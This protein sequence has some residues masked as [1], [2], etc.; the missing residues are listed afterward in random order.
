MRT[1][2][3]RRRTMHFPAD[4]WNVGLAISQAKLRKWFA[5]RHDRFWRHGRLADVAAEKTRRT[6]PPGLSRKVRTPNWLH[7]DRTLHARALPMTNGLSAPREIVKASAIFVLVAV[8]PILVWLFRDLILLVVG[9][10]VLAALLHL[11]ARPIVSW[12]RVPRGVALA[13]AGIFISA[14]IAGVGWIFGSRVI[15]ELSDVVGRAE[16]S[17]NVIRQE[18]HGGL[19]SQVFGA[20]GPSNVSLMSYVGAALQITTGMVEAAI[21][22]IVGGVYVAAEP[23]LYRK[24]LVLIFPSY[25]SA[26][27]HELLGDLATGL[28]LWL[29]GQLIQMVLVGLLSFLVLWL[30]G[31]P[32]PVGLGVIAAVCEFIPYLGPILAGVPAVLVAFSQSTSLAIW[33]ILAFVIIHQME[34]HLFVPLVQRRFVVIPPA[35]MLFGIV[36]VDLFFGFFGILVAAPLVVLVYFCVKKLYV[37]EGLG[38]NVTVPGEEH[39]ATSNARQA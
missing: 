22:I 2:T 30:I 1:D 26:T 5:H 24:G 20:I 11:V 34:G 18:L 21:I 13:I 19:L 38:R 9:A 12:F 36:T 16:S 37:R 7:V 39:P 17:L 23:E 14:I 33:T 4:V 32:S 10:L 27:I 15:S 6:G 3:V 28:R 31:V 29:I 8:T 35:A 25:D